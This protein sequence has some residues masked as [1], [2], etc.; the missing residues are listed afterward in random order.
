[1]DQEVRNQR[2]L[3]I[4]LLRKANNVFFWS[5]VNHG[6]IFSV[7]RLNGHWSVDVDSQKF[8]W[9]GDGSWKTDCHT[10]LATFQTLTL[11]LLA[12]T[13]DITFKSKHIIILSCFLDFFN[14]IWIANGVALNNLE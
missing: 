8:H 14:L 9:T 12:K 1:M 2:N 6:G 5:G 3:E 10:K 11:V 13:L 4:A 7:S